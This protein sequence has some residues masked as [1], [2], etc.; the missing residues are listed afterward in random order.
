MKNRNLPA[1][2]GC[3]LPGYKL[4]ALGY[5]ILAYAQRGRAQYTSLLLYACALSPALYLCWYVFPNFKKGT[6]Y[7]LPITDRTEA[8]VV[9]CERS[10]QPIESQ[11]ARMLRTG[12]IESPHEFHLF[13]SLW[14]LVASLL[15]V[16]TRARSTALASA[17]AHVR[18][19][20]IVISVRATGV[21]V[22]PINECL[23][24]RLAQSS[25]G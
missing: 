14:C 15:L 17:S 13:A 4:F 5:R 11:K 22:S 3:D 8:V 16:P 23:F 12:N 7:L 6:T 21:L 20:T 2:G 25:R 1:G 24:P 10:S 19:Q 18:S 9:R